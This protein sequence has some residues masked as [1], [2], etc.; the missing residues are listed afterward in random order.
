MTRFAF[1]DVT[2][3]SD[4]GGYFT[5]RWFQTGAVHLNSSGFREREFRRRQARRHVSHHGRRRFLHVW[6]RCAA[7]GRYSDLLQARLPSHFEVLNFGAPGANTPEHRSLVAHLLTDVHPDFVLLQ[8]YVNDTEDD[9]STGRPTFRPLMPVRSVHDW[10]ND[11]SALY[12]VA[13]MQW[14]KMQ[15][16]LGM[17]TSYSDYLN[18]RLGDPNG[19]DSQVDR[20]LLLDLI[21]RCQRAGVPARHRALPGYRRQHEQGLPVW[22]PPRS[23][24]GDLPGAEPDLRRPATRVFVD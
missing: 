22:I 20:G 3:S 6:Q 5:Q 12:T 4:N 7:G 19:H 18:L 9:D 11:V 16:A 24:T 2:T 21:A 14:A 13:N 10:L 15:V 8:W 23:R 1:R 17:T